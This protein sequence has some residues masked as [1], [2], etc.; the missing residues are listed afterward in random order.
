MSTPLG[1]DPLG[2]PAVGVATWLA[3]VVALGLAAVVAL[4]LA[5]VVALPLVGFS[6]AH[7]AFMSASGV[8]SLFGAT[9]N[10]T[11]KRRA[12]LVSRLVVGSLALPVTVKPCLISGK[13]TIVSKSPATDC[14]KIFISVHQLHIKLSYPLILGKN[15]QNGFIPVSF[16]QEQQD[17]SKCARKNTGLS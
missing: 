4:G 8:V 9:R 11:S 7:A 16:S 2:I 17:H 6:V 10:S 5:V 15:C 12:F 1:T 13:S 3:A 14:R